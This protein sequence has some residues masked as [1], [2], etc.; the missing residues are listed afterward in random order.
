MCL[1]TTKTFQ[2]AVRVGRSVDNE[3][4]LSLNRTSPPLSHRIFCVQVMYK[5]AVVY[6]GRRSFK[7]RFGGS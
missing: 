2:N 6:G 1:G 5:K 4:F 7:I 3:H